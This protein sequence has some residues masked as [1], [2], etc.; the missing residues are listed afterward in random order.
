MMKRD[1]KDKYSS[2]W[3]IA[4]QK[5]KALAM[6]SASLQQILVLPWL[7]SLDSRIEALYDDKPSYITL[8]SRLSESISRRFNLE[9]SVPDYYLV[10]LYIINPR[11]ALQLMQEFLQTHE[12][13]AL[14]NNDKPFIGF[15]INHKR[16]DYINNAT[17]T[18][19]KWEDSSKNPGVTA[20]QPG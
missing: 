9:Q 6:V 3:D 7:Q 8:L 14:K 18:D 4:A 16:V 2:S 1:A 20:P 15:I 10:I 12:A 5:K 11:A 17:T 13:T 19:V